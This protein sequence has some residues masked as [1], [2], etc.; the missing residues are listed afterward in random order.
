MTFP[1]GFFES[2]STRTKRLIYKFINRIFR[3]LIFSEH[4]IF[5]KWEKKSIFH[6]Q[7]FI[8]LGEYARTHAQQFKEVNGVH[9]CFSKEFLVGKGSQGTRVCVGLGK[10]GVK[11]AVKR[12]PRDACCSLAKFLILN[13]LKTKQSQYVVSFY[14]L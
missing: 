1:S 2:R 5:S 10:D 11:K 12:L 3:F 8:Y 14:T 6:H 13:Q 4:L 9:V 7:K